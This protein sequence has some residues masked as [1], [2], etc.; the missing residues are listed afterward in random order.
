MRTLQRRENAFKGHASVKRFFILN[1]VSNL[2]NSTTDLQIIIEILPQ[3]LARIKS[4]S[5][6]KCPPHFRRNAHL[7]FK[8]MPTSHSKKCPPH[9]QNNAHLIIKE[10]PTSYSPGVRSLQ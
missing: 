2:Q 4:K 5:K 1:N 6:Y 10:M 8:E 3:Y 7:I 9:I